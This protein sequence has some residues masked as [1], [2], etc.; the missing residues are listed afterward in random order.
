MI[1]N[2]KILKKFMMKKFMIK[3]ISLQKGQY[4][5]LTENNYLDTISVQYHVSFNRKNTDRIA[6]IKYN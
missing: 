2:G 5:K 1:K 4:E 3:T 6:K